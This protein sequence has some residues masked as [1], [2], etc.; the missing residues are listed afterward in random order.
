MSDSSPSRTELRTPTAAAVAGIAFALILGSVIVLAQR[1]IPR[2]VTSPVWV[3]IPSDRDK[4]R[5]ALTLIP[6]GGIAFLWFIGVIRTRLGERED[7][8]FATVFLGSGLLFVAMLFTGSAVLG[9]VLVLR[10]HGVP[11]SADA[12]ALLQ[13]LNQ[14]IMGSFATRMAAVFTLSVTS[15]ASRSGALPRWLTVW[16]IIS[17]LALFAAPL[18]GRWSQLVFPV[19]V[20]VLSVHLLVVR[21]RERAGAA[22]QGPLG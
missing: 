18:L 8:L 7:R 10:A 16:G 5:A 21:S 14:Q 17:A 13:A 1:S 2:D 12:M 19:W 3:D 9:S 20:L 22:A 6:F 11:V 15:L 4:V